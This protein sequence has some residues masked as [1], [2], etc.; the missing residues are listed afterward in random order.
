MDLPVHVIEDFFFP[1]M[2]GEVSAFM[3]I[4]HLTPF[5]IHTVTNYNLKTGCF[6]YNKKKSWFS[7]VCFPVNYLTNTPVLPVP[8]EEVLA[9]TPGSIPTLLVLKEFFFLPQLSLKNHCLCTLFYEHALNFPFWLWIAQLLQLLPCQL[10]RVEPVIKYHAAFCIE[11]YSTM[12]QFDLSDCN[13]TY[14]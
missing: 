3:C 10:T 8:V 5:Y 1:S 11:T 14:A 6:Y 9:A 13:N 2:F 12:L 4:L 7:I